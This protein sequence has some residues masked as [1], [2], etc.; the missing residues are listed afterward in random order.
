[1]PDQE[2]NS[3]QDMI[4]EKQ[5]ITNQRARR[6]YKPAYWVTFILLGLAI[7]AIERVFLGGT[8]VIVVG[9]IVAFLLSSLV[10]RQL[11]PPEK[12]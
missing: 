3:M 5:K 7:Y 6:R 1:M 2:K 11:F 4:H 9:P 8:I 10:A 12:K